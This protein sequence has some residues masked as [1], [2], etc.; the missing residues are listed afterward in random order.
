MKLRTDAFPKFT[1]PLLRYFR[2]DFAGQRSPSPGLVLFASFVA[3]VGSLIADAIIVEL[4]TK[5]YPSTKGYVHFQFSDYSKLTI[6][7][8]IVACVGWPIVTRVSSSAR[9]LYY[10]AAIAVTVVLLVPDAFIWH[11][12]SPVRAV[13]ILVLMHIAI[14]I[15]TYNALVHLAAVPRAR[16]AR[17]TR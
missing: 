6:I 5:L 17:Q 11:Q 16:H 7:G 1:Q 13:F 14:A 8:V 15:V 9:W 10:R 12:G 2:V 4:G 3:L